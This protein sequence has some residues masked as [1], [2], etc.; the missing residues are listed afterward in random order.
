MKDKKNKLWKKNRDSISDPFEHEY[1]KVKKMKIIKKMTLK[2]Q[3]NES[4]SHNDDTFS[5]FNEYNSVN[6]GGDIPS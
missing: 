5:N 1:F 3:A 2:S 4:S 6:Y